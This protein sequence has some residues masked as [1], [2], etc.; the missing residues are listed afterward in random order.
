MITLQAENAWNT[1]ST[2]RKEEIMD[3]LTLKT[4]GEMD[5]V[6]LKDTLGEFFKEKYK[7]ANVAKVIVTLNL[8]KDKFDF[9]L[10]Y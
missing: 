5:E 9:V 8:E 6:Q 10:K 7:N 3:I 1:I 4:L 2:Y